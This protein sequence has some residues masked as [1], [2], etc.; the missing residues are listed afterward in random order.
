MN[1]FIT[2]WETGKK[3]SEKAELLEKKW[4][5]YPE[6]SPFYTHLCVGELTFQDM[7]NNSEY[8]AFL[9]YVQKFVRYYLKLAYICNLKSGLIGESPV[10][11]KQINSVLINSPAYRNFQKIFPTLERNILTSARPYRI[12]SLYDKI[13]AFDL[14]TNIDVFAYILIGYQDGIRLNLEIDQYAVNGKNIK[15]LESHCKNKAIHTKQSAFSGFILPSHIEME[16][17]KK[18]SPLS[19]KKTDC[20]GDR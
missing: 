6:Q 7:A 14:Q 11:E 20:R 19:N 5:V 9:N 13:R 8:H 15:Q 17:Y 1:D 3:I 4:G 12:G 2:E 10:M 16:Y 18:I